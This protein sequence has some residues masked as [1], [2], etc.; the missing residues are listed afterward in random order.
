[1]SG[2]SVD[3]LALREP[4]DLSARNV[5]VR[6]RVSHHVASLSR[7]TLTD[8]ASGTG[9]T[10]GALGPHLPAHQRWHL[11]DHDEALLTVAQTR[12]S[13]GNVTI[14]THHLDLAGNV[15]AALATSPNMVTTSALLDLVSLPWLDR[16]V[17]A[18]TDHQVPVY[19]ALTYNGEIDFGTT[20]PH[21]D[22]IVAAVNAH[23]RTDKGFGPALGPAAAPTAIALWE[24]HGYSVVQ[25]TSDWSMGVADRVI[26]LE[27]LIGWATA[28]REAQTLAAADIEAW[29]TGRTNDVFNGSATMRVGHTDFFAIPSVQ[30]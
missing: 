15:E 7:V 10:L 8:L 6:D 28:A 22:A 13:G 19:A 9:S 11:F 25:G 23:Q 17:V 18:T 3:W 26:Q 16:L 4:F 20:H 12:A 21:D 2:F 14:D 27:L 30:R 24:S 5:A 29:L 1:M